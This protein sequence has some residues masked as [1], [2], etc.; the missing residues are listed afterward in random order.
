[1]GQAA[2]IDAYNQF[3]KTARSYVELR[4]ED[5]YQQALTT[6]EELLESAEDTVD[7]PLN[8]LIDM[9]SNS[10]E[11]YEAQDDELMEFVIQAESVSL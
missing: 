11:A 1:M 10:I 5:D 2:L 4:S 7:E 3:M 8:P 9:I 6:L